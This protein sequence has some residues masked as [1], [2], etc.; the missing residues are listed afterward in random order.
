MFLECSMGFGPRISRSHALARAERLAMEGGFW[1]W[2]LEDVRDA[3]DNVPQKRLLDVARLYLP[4]GGIMALIERAVATG[5]GRGIRQGGP[6]SP[7]LLNL[8]LHHVLDRKWRRCRPDLPLLRVADDLLV[9]CRSEEEA[10]QAR[11]T[12][13]LILTPAGMPLKAQKQPTTRNLTLG[14]HA[15]WL[16]YRVTRG[17]GGVQTRLTEEEVWLGRLERKLTLAHEKADAPSRAIDIVVGWVQQQGPCYP[18]T[19]ARQTYARVIHLAHTLGFE[20]IPLEQQFLKQWQLAYARWC[21]VRDRGW[22]AS[23]GGASDGRPATRRD[24]DRRTAAA[25]PAGNESG[26]SRPATRGQ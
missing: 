13:E 1:V 9:L 22:K 23:S 20:E 11:R 2:L 3:F 26:R 19:D 16:G 25:S 17:E 7:L 15:D 24:P 5:T 4:D 8:Y 12:L 10:E 18:H 6:L 14:D 21:K